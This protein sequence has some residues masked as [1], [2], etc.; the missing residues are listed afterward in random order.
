LGFGVRSSGFGFRGSGSG[1][2]RGRCG[3]RPNLSRE[4][5]RRRTSRG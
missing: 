4:T 5:S 2:T 3:T 1:L